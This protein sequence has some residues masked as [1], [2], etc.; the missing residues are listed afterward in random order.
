MAAKKTNENV[1][2]TK[3][4]ETKTEEKTNNEENKT[5]SGLSYK[6]EI[7]LIYLIPLV[8]FIFAL[9]KEKKVSKSSRFHYNQVGTLWIVNM[10]LSIGFGILGAFIPFSGLISST[11]SIVLFVFEI[12][13]IVKAYSDNID[14][15][16][17]VIYDLS[18]SIFGNKNED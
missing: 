12:I 16:I 14:Y 7:V 13:A 5:I 8:G 17:P 15:K 18:K 1:E 3:V 10:V 4:V 11:L 2:E 6:A 9:M